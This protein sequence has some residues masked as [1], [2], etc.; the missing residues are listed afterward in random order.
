[1]RQP[2]SDASWVV[3]TDD[4]SDAAW[5]LVADDAQEPNEGSQPTT[6][7]TAKLTTPT[8]EEASLECM[9]CLGRLPTMLFERCGHLG[10][11]GHCA[12]FMLN[13]Q[14]MKNKRKGSSKGAAN[15]RKLGLNKLG[16]LSLQCP[17]CR[18]TSRVVHVSKYSGQ[19][20]YA[21]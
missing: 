6:I 4:R 16:H 9:V 20:I 2:R 11:C 12:K 8:K 10:V 5:V 13:E 1:M 19:I 15:T 3:V 14:N 21:V 7:S 17:C 18:A